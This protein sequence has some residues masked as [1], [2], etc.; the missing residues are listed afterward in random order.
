MMATTTHPHLLV[1]Q[2]DKIYWITF[3]RPEKL[4]C[5]SDDM[6]DALVGLLDELEADDSVSVIVFRG[7]G[8]CFSTGYDINPDLPLPRNSEEARRW[9]N[10]RYAYLDRIWAIPKPFIAQVHGY[11]LAGASDLAN[12]CDLTVAADDAT[13]GYPA[14]RWGGHTHRLTYAWSLPM[15]KAREMMFTGDSIT[16]AEALALGM[17]NRVV[18]REELGAATEALAERIAL[19]PLSGLITNKLSLNYADEVRGYRQSMAFT[20]QIANTNMF[21]DIEFFEVAREQGLK[22]ALDRRDRPFD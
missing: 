21:R 5:F 14:I 13:F 11:C 1:E 2:T 18:P 10:R 9:A 12:T 22:A 16:A 20:N 7:N 15:K 6:L 3:N 4:N 19:T 8:R 17:V